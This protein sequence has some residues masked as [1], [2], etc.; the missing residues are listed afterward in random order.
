MNKILFIYPDIVGGASQLHKDFEELASLSKEKINLFKYVTNANESRSLSK[1]T[2]NDLNKLGPFEK[3][4]F[5]NQ[6]LWES[7][8]QIKANEYIADV[9]NLV[10]LSRNS[11]KKAL[12]AGV[13]YY[14]GSTL[15]KLEKEY[16]FLGAMELVQAKVLKEVD[17]VWSNSQSTKQELKNKLGIVS[18]LVP[19]GSSISYNITKNQGQKRRRFVFIGRPTISK[20]FYKLLHPGNRELSLRVIGHDKNCG[21][22]LDA[23]KEDFPNFTFESFIENGEIEL[24]EDEI[25]IAV[26][27]YESFG[28]TI[29]EY[30]KSGGR[31]LAE[32]NNSGYREQLESVNGKCLINFSKEDLNQIDIS[33][34]YTRPQQFVLQRAS[35]M[36]KSLYE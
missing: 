20:G 26:S 19:V 1:N 4:V 32:I 21:L 11:L 18:S 28:F 5:V 33:D 34:I 16:R 13:K 22:E 27:D 15:E 6:E 14:S 7:V 31:L 36:L 12:E 17:E 8:K 9:H 23:I 29:Q 2:V 24:G 10:H 35:I 30:L 25:L 3:V